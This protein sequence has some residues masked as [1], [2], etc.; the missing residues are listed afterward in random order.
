MCRLFPECAPTASDSSSVTNPV[1]KTNREIKTEKP[2]GTEQKRPAITSPCTGFLR[3]QFESVRQI[4]EIPDIEYKSAMQ[5]INGLN[6]LFQP[7]Y[8]TFKAAPFRNWFL[9]LHDPTNTDNNDMLICAYL[10]DGGTSKARQTLT[11]A[12][13]EEIIL[14]SP[15]GRKIFANV[16]KRHT[17]PKDEERSPAAKQF[18][19]SNVLQLKHPDGFLCS[20]VLTRRLLFEAQLCGLLRYMC[21]FDARCVPLLAMV[22]YWA[23]VNRIRFGKARVCNELIHLLVPTPASL[24]WLVMTF[25]VGVKLVPTPRQIRS[26]EHEPLLAT[27][28]IPVDIGFNADPMFTQ[29]WWTDP[30]RVDPPPEFDSD[31][32]YLSILQLAQQFFACHGDHFYQQNSLINTLDGELQN[33]LSFMGGKKPGDTNLTDD[34]I[35]ILM[36]LQS[37]KDI[38]IRLNL[39]TTPLHVLNPLWVGSSLHVRIASKKEFTRISRFMRATGDELE[40]FLRKADNGER[41]TIDLKEYLKVQARYD[42]NIGELIDLY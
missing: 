16:T 1:A 23:R 40:S 31:E 39:T 28:D 38:R 14:T 24:D 37:N 20:I 25:L 29:E 33:L 9:K 7:L 32:F 13:M 22:R 8:P 10:T 26:R 27:E 12:R 4:M 15:K 2:A 6:E 3:T 36:K 17:N 30:K 42:N 11:R 18:G 19:S 21:S 35:N 41:D 5:I 34:E